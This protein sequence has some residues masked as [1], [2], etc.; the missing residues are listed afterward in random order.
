ME[1]S[2][3]ALFES[4]KAEMSSLSI[5]VMLPRMLAAAFIGTVLSLR[6]WRLPMRRALPKADMIQAQVLLC[7]AAAV[8]TAV[9]GDSVAK[10][11]GL[12]GL[13]GFVRFR[14]GLKDPR[15]AA[16][17][18][19]MIGLGMACGHGSLGLAGVGTVFVAALLFVLDLF[20]RET[21]VATRQRLLVSAQADDL[22]GA[23][24]SLRSALRER[25]V[26]VKSC[27]LDFDGRR[28]ELEVEEPVP[29]SL[30][31]A[32]GRTEGTPLRGLRWTAVGPKGT[33]EELT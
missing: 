14:S 31:A 15:D 19:L 17:L 22:V 26:L 23:E 13:G 8:I 9:I 11:F 21:P 30:T 28:L 2:I 6:P 24:A 25:N 1:V 4:A 18:F 10:A 16:I 32:L 33:R 29:G 3:P 12:V 7:A 20:N 27:A 5:T